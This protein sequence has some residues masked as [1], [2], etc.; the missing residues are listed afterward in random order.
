MLLAKTTTLLTPLPVES[1]VCRPILFGRKT[2]FVTLVAI[3]F[4]RIDCFVNVMA[5]FVK[6]S[7][8]ASFYIVFFLFEYIPFYLNLQFPPLETHL[9][10]S[11]GI[12]KTVLKQQILHSRN[13]QKQSLMCIY[14]QVI[15]Q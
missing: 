3:N 11:I 8:Y 7:R 12:K 15:H 6:D 4:K 2:L 13:L 5:L 14:I 10:T 9:L 1:N